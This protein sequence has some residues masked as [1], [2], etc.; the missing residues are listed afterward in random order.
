[1]ILHTIIDAADIFYKA[2]S[3][4]TAHRI[5][6]V[7]FYG[8]DEPDGFHVARIVSTDLNDYLQYDAAVGKVLPAGGSFKEKDGTRQ[9]G[10]DKTK[11]CRQ[12]GKKADGKDQSV[13]S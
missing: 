3:S 10:T 5:G 8:T 7:L 12:N 11:A 2:P 9:H 13:S 6:N 1:M 4:Y